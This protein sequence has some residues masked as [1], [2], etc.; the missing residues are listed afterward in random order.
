MAPGI[1]GLYVRC[2]VSYLNWRYPDHLSLIQLLGVESVETPIPERVAAENFLNFL[3]RA[4]EATGNPSFGLH[5][6]QFV[7]IDDFEG[8]GFLLCSC[9]NFRDVLEQTLRFEGLC[10]DLGKSE[11]VNEDRMT[12]YRFHPRFPDH[13]GTPHLV[14][15]VA[16]G[17]RGVANW[18][19]RADL[20]VF[21]FSFQHRLPAGAETEA[22]KRILNAP[23]A[24]GA[25][26]SEACFPEALLDFPLPTANLSLF[27]SM[28]RIVAERL[29]A[30]NR[31]QEPE[32]IG[33]TSAAIEQQ[34]GH[35][36]AQIER[37]A[38]SMDMSARTLQRRLA[39]ADSSFADLLAATRRSLA[40]A[41]LKDGKLSILEVALLLGFNE[42][43]SFNKAFRN[44]FGAS[45]T[46]W[47]RK[48][49]G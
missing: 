35:G 27:A 11:V 2:C 34:I 45:P 9:K 43:S 21:Q 29:S 1:S 25:T 19:A 36:K 13:P 4:A 42:Q 44:W 24:F 40:E 7:R 17:L 33:Q 31:S 5:M 48:T 22:Y 15:A 12:H 16:S 41:Y 23:I 30:R 6:G 14:E 46:E 49:S 37:V 47:R 26:C 32:I 20:P 28:E 8:Y 18:L 3:A 10:H 39:E 38:H